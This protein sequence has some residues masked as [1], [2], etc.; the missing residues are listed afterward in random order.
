MNREPLNIETLLE[1]M[2]TVD[3]PSDSVHRYELRRRLL[4]S[5]FFDVPV[6]SSRWN[7]LLGY[8]APLVA[9]GMLVG[10]FSLVAVSVSESSGSPQLISTSTDVSQVQNETRPTLN[11]FASDPFEP[12]V[13]LADIQTFSAQDQ[14]STVESVRFVPLTE[15]SVILTQ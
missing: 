2:E 9:G 14:T 3:I 8:T 12:R 15:R 6:F 4:C 13:Q 7:R 10:V 11:A 1:A 5:R